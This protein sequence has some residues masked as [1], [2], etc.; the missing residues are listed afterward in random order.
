MVGPTHRHSNIDASKAL[1][2]M[3]SYVVEMNFLKN[4]PNFLGCYYAKHDDCKNNNTCPDYLI[5]QQ[6]QLPNVSWKS[7]IILEDLKRNYPRHVADMNQQDVLRAMD[8]LVTLHTCP[9]QKE[10]VQYLWRCGTYWSLDKRKEENDKMIRRWFE[11]YT[12]HLENSSE[13]L[14]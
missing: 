4:F 8:W 1:I 13:I 11:I 5:N 6:Q 10:T 3:T 9:F 14:I 12:D 2:K 7:I